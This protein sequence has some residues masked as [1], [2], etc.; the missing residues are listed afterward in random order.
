[1]SPA[2][3][4]LHGYGRI[5]WPDLAVALADADSAWADYHG[6]HIGQC[7]AQP[8]PYTHLWAWHADW[9]LRARIDGRDAIVGALLLGDVGPPGLTSL[10]T[11]RTD[12]VRREGHTWPAEEKRVGPV[13]AALAGRDVDLYQ[14]AGAHPVTFVRL[15]ST[16]GDG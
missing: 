6:F 9:L 12:C 14:I 15:R 8:P 3:A 16:R 7:P 5:P 10:L 13:P 2:T 11:D 4:T 1:M